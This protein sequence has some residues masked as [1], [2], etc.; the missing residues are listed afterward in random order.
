[1]RR[2]VFVS[3]SALLYHRYR[4]LIEII[5]WTEGIDLSLLLYLQLPTTGP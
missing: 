2:Y 5:Q 3:V 1:M 4:L